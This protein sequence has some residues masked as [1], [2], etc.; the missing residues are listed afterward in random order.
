MPE[1]CERNRAKD[2]GNVRLIVEKVN[3][4]VR[5]QSAGEEHQPSTSLPYMQHATATVTLNVEL[6]QHKQTPMRI[7]CIKHK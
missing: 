6:E 5:K 3:Q 7:N 2:T 4:K 1:R